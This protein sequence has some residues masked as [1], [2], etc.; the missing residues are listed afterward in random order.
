MSNN[1]AKSFVGDA[2][3]SS[4]GKTT[5]PISSQTGL[6]MLH[7]LLD[8]V[9][10]KFD[11]NRL[12]VEL[13]RRG[14]IIEHYISD[15]ASTQTSTKND[16]D[17]HSHLHRSTSFSEINSSPPK[18]VVP[19]TATAATS[20]A[21]ESTPAVAKPVNYWILMTLSTKLSLK[22]AVAENLP[23]QPFHQYTAIQRVKLTQC[24]IDILMKNKTTWGIVDAWI[25]HDEVLYKQ[26]MIT[27]HAD[28]SSFFAFGSK[29]P[30]PT[31][32]TTATA[33]ATPTSAEVE[34]ELNINKT[35]SSTRNRDAENTVNLVYQY[36]GPQIAFYF[37]FLQHYTSSLLIPSIVGVVVYLHQWW[38]NMTDTSLLPYYVILLAIWTTWFLESWKRASAL[39]S[40]QW[41]VLGMDDLEADIEIAKV[42]KVV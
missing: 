6:V 26:M 18:V 41:G 13:R 38:Y 17:I 12:L 16:K 35:K 30:A 5:R 8:P 7:C 19:N 28:A 42:S 4:S 24:A 32:A 33:A 31:T 36:F 39:H 27:S 22:L 10:V 34:E 29:K 15:Q 14:F 37:G 1:K 23:I 25:A 3:P 11:L 2:L 21:K 9:K 20:N 40:F